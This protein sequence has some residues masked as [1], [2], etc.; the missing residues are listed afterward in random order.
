MKCSLPVPSI[1]LLKQKPYCIIRNKI[2]KLVFNLSYFTAYVLA[3]S[4]YDVWLP[5]HRGNTYSRAHTTLSVNSR[6]YWNFSWHELGIYDL[7][8]SI[9]YILNYTNHKNLLFSGHSQ[10][11]T[12]YLVLTSVRP[13]YNEK[14]RAG[15]LLAPIGFMA[16]G[17]SEIM[18]YLLGLGN[19]L[20]VS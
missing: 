5:N 9:D 16:H 2:Y 13:E 14:I 4:C 7:P 18:K 8:A 3:D 20:T 10:G 12:V 17:K 19:V 6:E 1:F 15:F 11:G